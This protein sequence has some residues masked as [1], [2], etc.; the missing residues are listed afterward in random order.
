MKKNFLR[1]T[2]VF[3][4]VLL[5]AAGAFAATDADAVLKAVLKNEMEFFSVDHDRS[6][7]LDEFWSLG[8]DEGPYMPKEYSCFAV[9]D[10]DRDG[11]PEIVLDPG[12]P[13]VFHYEDGVVYAWQLGSRSMQ[14]LK[15]DGSYHGSNGA[16]AGA[17]IRV[18]KFDG[19]TFE[20]EYLGEYSEEY[21][22]DGNF[23]SGEYKIKGKS[24]SKEEYD[25]MIDELIDKNFADQLDFTEENMEKW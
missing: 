4:L 18:K 24:V 21:D 20:E 14:M 8:C 16:S 23:L 19:K 12:A 13:I 3:A 6:M 1:L 2:L 22:F 25:R 11:V 5:S 17:F 7:K 10:M 15:K 9:V